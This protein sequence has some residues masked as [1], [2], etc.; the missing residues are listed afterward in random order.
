MCLW[1]CTAFRSVEMKY[2]V[3]WMC[4]LS[5]VADE[6]LAHSLTTT[7]IQ[8]SCLFLPRKTDIEEAAFPIYTNCYSINLHVKVKYFIVNTYSTNLI[9]CC[10]RR[11]S[12][13]SV[14]IFYFLIQEIGLKTVLL[15][16]MTELFPKWTCHFPSKWFHNIL[17]SLPS[18]PL[19]L[20]W[21]VVSLKQPSA[22]WWWRSSNL[23]IPGQGIAESG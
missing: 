18:F 7:G 2:S 6:W 15:P 16:E 22:F 12:H 1:H 8:R 10:T 19:T 5:L 14:S 20:T 13:N 11:S 21:T 4:P 17:G 23:H 3:R 9:N